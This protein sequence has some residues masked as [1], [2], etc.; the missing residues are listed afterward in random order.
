MKRVGGAGAGGASTFPTGRIT[1]SGSRVRPGSHIRKV[2]LVLV[3]VTIASGIAAVA[4]VAAAQSGVPGSPAITSVTAGT[5]IATLAW[6]PPLSTGSSTIT[7]YAITSSPGGITLTVPGT[8]ETAT[9]DGLSPQ[10]PYTFTVTAAN[11]SGAGSPSSP[12]SAVTP[13][14]SG[15][16]Y[17]PVHPNRIADTRPGSNE[18]YSGHT[19]GPGSSLSVQVAG[20][21]GVPTT[22]ATAA[23]LNV[24]VTGTTASSYLTIWPAGGARPT[25]SNLNWTAGQTVANLTEVQLGSGG[26][27]AV[28]N[29][30]GLADVVVDVQGYATDGAPPGAAAGLYNPLPPERL[31]DTRPGSNE[32]EAG[33]TLGPGSTLDVPVAGA[34][35]VPLTGAVAA[36][37]NLTATGASRPTYLTVWPTGSPRPLASD[38]NI[39]PGQTRA[40]RLAVPLGTGGEVS[41][42]NNS[43]DV[44]VIIDA[45]GYYTP[46][47][48]GSG[49][50]G[51]GSYLTTESPQRIAD[52]R[53][54]SSEPYAGDTLYS[55]GVL[56]VQVAGKGGV[57][58]ETASVPPLSAVL[59]V[60]A[61][62]AEVPTYLTVYP[63]G[64]PTPLASDVNVIP[65]SPTPNLVVAKLGGNGGVDIYNY[66]GAVDIV[67]DVFG[68]LS[69]FT[70]VP[71][72]TQVLSAASEQVL[73]SASP[74]G[75]T[76][77]FSSSTPQLSA[78]LPGDTLALP[79][80]SY[81]PDGLLRLVTGVSTSGS[82]VTVTTAPTDL[83]HALAGGG[84]STGG[85]L[86]PSAVA[87]TQPNMQGAMLQ[88]A[89][90]PSP[91]CGPGFTVALSDVP[92][93]SSTSGSITA[94]GCVGMSVSS[95][96]SVNFPLF[97]SPQVSFS[98]SASQTGELA[99]SATATVAASYSDSVDLGEDILDPIDLQIGPVPVV[100][101]PE[102]DF[103][104]SLDGQVT[105]GIA[106]S[107][108]EEAD[109]S[110]G[111]TCSGGGCSP[112]S[113]FDHTVNGGTPLVSGDASVKLSAGPEL[114]ILI[115][116]I[117]GPTFGV[118]GFTELDASATADPW[119]TLKAG[120]E[121]TAGITFK[122]LDVEVASY[123]TTVISVTWPVAQAPGGL[124]PLTLVTQ[125]PSLV[126]LT[127][128]AS[129]ITAIVV[130][131]QG[132][133][134]PG[135]SV[136]FAVSP[137]SCGTLSA[138]SVTTGPGGEAQDTYT[139]STKIE[140][141]TVTA[142][143]AQGGHTAT[144]T[145]AQTVSFLPQL[146]P[147]GASADNPRSLA[148]PSATTC[149][150]LAVG[151]KSGY[152]HLYYTA[153]SG[154]MWVDITGAL[155][156]PARASAPAGLS[157]VSV[158]TCFLA[159]GIA[160][161]LP[162]SSTLSVWSTDV[163][164]TTDAGTSWTDEYAAMPAGAKSMAASNRDSWGPPT[165]ISCAPPGTCI[166]LVGMADM[167]TTTPWSGVAAYSMIATT[168][169]GNT[170]VDRTP[171]IP[172]ND[173]L[174][175]MVSCFT[176]ED[177]T[178][179]GLDDAYHNPYF[180]S[181]ISTGDGGATW[182]NDD[183]HL[184]PSVQ[185]A[186]GSPSSSLMCQSVAG[187]WFAGENSAVT[188]DFGAPVMVESPNG[189]ST[190][191]D[192]SQNA[193]PGY[194]PLCVENSGSPL[195]S[196]DYCGG[197]VQM[198]AVACS[199]AQDCLA[200]GYG[201]PP[202]STA[203]QALAFS[204][205]DGGE[206]FVDDSAMFPPG[207]RD[208]LLG[209]SGSN[210]PSQSLSCPAVETCYLLGVNGASQASNGE[211]A[212]LSTSRP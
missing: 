73:A 14:E 110:A 140:T 181:V 2:A 118:D 22:G 15:S 150:I 201:Q 10:T 178:V 82:T 56:A 200:V 131:T 92:L 158:S 78:L 174:P 132:Q 83:G 67:V 190:W 145:I 203:N 208:F 25:A 13:T 197:T 99:L 51:G 144:A 163:F 58:P 60:T 169:G 53:S 54:G 142:T 16:L 98:V 137:S 24:T 96:F 205:T 124:E 120:I 18:P 195:A 45:G 1:R 33:H 127:S 43:G 146:L 151:P 130:S 109:M 30:S 133:P 136:S 27:V 23:T 65:G 160:I 189:G 74:R 55:G 66:S 125:S 97:Q 28:Y 75:S 39:A 161:P 20:V 84:F 77:T 86:D 107:V 40:N 93:F 164:K 165:A 177:C 7:S 46:P 26:Q 57:P 42:Y 85:T 204:T 8:S 17:V 121:A 210:T 34:G 5:G 188:A 76:L 155:P 193:P 103:K 198:E 211:L 182:T 119:W 206:S 166:V 139:A 152:P 31:A 126:A 122:L 9:V 95:N 147:P 115:Y 171:G 129:T 162:G 44:N 102:L 157:C 112:T 63:A 59:N 135:D 94:S 3:M 6:S 128:S 113:S 153:D 187:C 29:E 183:P 50:A 159:A 70:V 117:V 180:E 199:S 68:Y 87:S 35:G 186:G 90:S 88:E 141:C 134:V 91:A 69:G 143:D 196:T 72:T 172:I 111:L 194:Y 156:S 37:L 192:L 209:G 47:S 116:G 79:S 202:S 48:T 21:G 123:S 184:P 176:A 138:P 154:A 175:W 38:L 104:I 81:T 167:P 179:L 191:F 41:V 49:G 105:V 148:C 212:L 4:P 149:Y 207:Y 168:D 61:V 173:F 106:D 100:L 12:S 108:T 32:P 185:P 64:V 71:P 11:A 52:T 62:G 80:S 114:D 89:A 36:V 101:V 19:L 170:W